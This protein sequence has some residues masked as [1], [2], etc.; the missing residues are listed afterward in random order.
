MAYTKLSRTASLKRD[1]MLAK[2]K[3]ARIAKKKAAYAEEKAVG[4]QR[5]GSMPGKK[6]AYNTKTKTFKLK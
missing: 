1:D 2:K 3:K 6:A 5:S 4:L